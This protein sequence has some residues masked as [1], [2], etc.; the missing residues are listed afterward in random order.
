MNCQWL[1]IFIAQLAVGALFLLTGDSD[2]ARVVF[3]LAIGQG[4]TATKTRWSLLTQ[5]ALVSRLCL[6]RMPSLGAL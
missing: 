2:Y 3:V 1:A 6:K 5:H 4:M